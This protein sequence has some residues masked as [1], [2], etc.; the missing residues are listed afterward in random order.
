[1]EAAPVVEAARD[2]SFL[3]SSAIDEENIPV[4]SLSSDPRECPL[5]CRWTMKR[6]KLHVPISS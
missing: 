5:T 4:V 2:K 1:M 6:K 3:N